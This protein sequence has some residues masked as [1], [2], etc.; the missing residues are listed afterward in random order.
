MLVFTHLPASVFRGFDGLEDS[1]QD[2]FPKPAGASCLY[3]DPDLG[4]LSDD[5][6]SGD[7]EENY[8]EDDLSP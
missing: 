5:D 4:S 6:G 2:V 3:D 8:G 1:G 7:D